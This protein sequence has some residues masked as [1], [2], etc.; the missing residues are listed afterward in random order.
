MCYTL[1]QEEGGQLLLRALGH[2]EDSSD[3]EDEE[4]NDT[5]LDAI[6]GDTDCSATG[7]VKRTALLGGMFCAPTGVKGGLTGQPCVVDC[8]GMQ[9]VAQRLWGCLDE[10]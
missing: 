7:N 2:E 4:E 9:Q 5:A 8:R 3:D 1:L 10:A 6:L